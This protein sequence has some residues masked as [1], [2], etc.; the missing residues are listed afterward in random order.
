[1]KQLNENTVRQITSG[2]V[3]TSVSNVVK[4]LIENSIDAG[5]TN[6]D[7]KL[8]NF[9]LDLLEIKDNGSG[10]S[11]D[12]IELMVASHYTSKISDF[13]DLEK[14]TSYGFRGE[15]L[16]SLCSVTST[17]EIMSKRDQDQLAKIVKFDKNSKKISENNVAATRGTIIKAFDIFDNLPVRRNYYKKSL[18]RRK[19]DLKK[20]ETFI[21]AYGLIHPKLRISLSHNKVHGVI[22]RILD[23]K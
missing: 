22:L 19:E 18:Q 14:V 6:I 12:N 5:A 7:V 10:V 4:E 23:L 9:G 17:L 3:V 15:A 16:H 11:P 1:M 2:Q 21:W 13:Q 8:I 20:I